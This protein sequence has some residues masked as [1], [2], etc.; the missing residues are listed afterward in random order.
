M[1][2]IER[3]ITGIDGSEARFIG[4]VPDNSPEMDSDRHRTSILILPGGGYAMTSDRESEPVALRFLAKGFNVF[5]LRYSVKPSRYPVAL[6][7]AAE[8]MRLIRAHADEWHVKPEAIAILGFSAGGHLAANLATSAGDDTMRAHNVNPDEVRPNALMLAYPV[9]TAGEFA[10]RGSFQCLLGLE[11][12]NP[13]L[14]DELSIERHIDAK[15]PPVFVWHTMTDATVPVEN[16]LML[17]QA[18]RAAGV[19]VEAH[20]YPEGTHG[21]SLANEET[22]GAGKYAHIV[23]CLQSWPELAETWLRRLF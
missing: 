20:L 19:S 17:I 12:H 7:E 10:H 11:A 9:I 3:A 18:C 15:T 21:L 4:Y 16:T 1:Q 13:E 8:A 22:A 5:I 14:L 2:Y 23:E 6:L